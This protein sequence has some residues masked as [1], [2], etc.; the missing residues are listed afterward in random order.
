MQ[1]Q[2]GSRVNEALPP[3]KPARGHFLISDFPRLNENM[4]TDDALEL[5]RT[6]NIFFLP[7]ER[8]G[9]I[10]GVIDRY[11]IYEYIDIQN[12]INTIS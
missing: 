10:V 3:Y 11:S 2:A 8:E 12:R 4:K 1:C 9:E 5:M 6:V 7:I